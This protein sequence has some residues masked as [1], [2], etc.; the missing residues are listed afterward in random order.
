MTSIIAPSSASLA[1]NGLPRPVRPNYGKIHAQRLPLATHSLPPLIPHNPLSLLQIVFTYVRQYLAPPSSHPKQ[2]IQGYFSSVTRSVH[3]A[4]EASIRRLWESGFFGKG[5][6]SRSESTWLDRERRRQG[7]LAKETSEEYTR[8]RRE[9]RKRF[10]KER[11]RKEREAIEEK[12]KQEKLGSGTDGDRTAPTQTPGHEQLKGP[13]TNGSASPL[14]ARISQQEEKNSMTK[15]G[16]DP[17]HEAIFRPLEHNTN[18]SAHA[19]EQIPSPPPPV[20]ENQEHLQ[21]TLEEAFFLVYG[22]GILQIQPDS[23]YIPDPTTNGT[24]S[25]TV[26]LTTSH[27]LTLFRT[28]SYFP[29][30]SPLSLPPDDT[31]L[32]SYVIYHHFRSLGWVVRPGIKFG[33]DWLLYLRGP[34]FSHAEFAIIVI[35]AYTHRYWRATEE[36]QRQTRKKESESWWWLHCTQRVQ[37]QVK[38]S[39]VLAYVDIPPPEAIASPQISKLEREAAMAKGVQIEEGAV[40]IGRILKQYKVREMI[41]KRWIPN[42][43]RD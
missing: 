32:T 2:L 19:T 20:I 9:E 11:A 5:S 33:V 18:G 8:Q 29:P 37:S 13:V 16:S 3:I 7:L 15:R 27:L 6:L 4:D 10:K 39:L 22:L 36:R 12:L 17:Q 21:L 42:R 41:V 31:F 24:L 23:T 35:P 14:E 43:S 26:A 1:T 34:V 25:L 30:T 28:H 38:K 40:D